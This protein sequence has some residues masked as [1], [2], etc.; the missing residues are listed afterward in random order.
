MQA[1]PGRRVKRGGEPIAAF[2]G[3][4]ESLLIGKHGFQ[5]QLAEQRVARREAVI[6]RALWSAQALRDGID[7]D[8]ARAPFASQRASRGEKAR[9][10]EKC[11]SHQSRLLSLDL[12]VNK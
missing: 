8:C 7:R 5:P 4:D 12:V 2:D 3:R 9:I 1:R 10:V 11:S 6:E